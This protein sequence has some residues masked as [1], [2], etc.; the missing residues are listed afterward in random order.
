MRKGWI[1]GVSGGKLERPLPSGPVPQRAPAGERE[2]MEG[3][4]PTETT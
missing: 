4:A 3:D 2:A 1:G